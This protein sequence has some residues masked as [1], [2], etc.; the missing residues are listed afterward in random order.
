[1]TFPCKQVGITAHPSHTLAVRS[2]HKASGI[3]EDVD[4]SALT[5]T[6]RYIEGDRNAQR[7]L[8]RMI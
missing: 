4:D 5:T 3:L 1:V 6:E 7:L 8:V 2:V